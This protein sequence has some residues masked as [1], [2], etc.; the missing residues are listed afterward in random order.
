M[1]AKPSTTIENITPEIAKRYLLTNADHQRKPTMTHQL[2]LRQQMERG[3]WMMTGEPIIFDSNGRL[4]DGQHRLRALIDAK[5]NIEFVVIRGVSPD[6]FMAMNRGK[7]RSNGNILEI[8]GVTNA[9]NIAACVS[10]VLNYR[11][12]L[13]ANDGKGGSLNSYIRASSCEIVKEYDSHKEEYHQSVN[14]AMRTAKLIC[15]SDGDKLPSR[16]LISCSVSSTV[17]ALAMIDA[18]RSFDEVD[19]FWKSFQS[20]SKLDDG[21]PIFTFRNRMILNGFSKSK[22]SSSLITMMAIK[23]WNA[24]IGNKSMKI[25][26]VSESEPVIPVL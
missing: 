18:K 7:P 12:A 20:G 10:G 26:R 1:K 4:V 16:R 23:A 6:S 14:V 13:Q 22:L 2:H 19:Y 8:H 24:Y 3:Q 21:D 9:R 25:L 5:A 17:S 15:Q 11:R